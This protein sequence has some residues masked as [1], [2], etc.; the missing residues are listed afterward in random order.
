MT[1]PV[2]PNEVLMTGEN[3]FIRLSS[4]GGESLSDRLSHWRV[5]W[6]PAGAGHALFI[7][8]E[9]TGG[10]FQIY[11]DNIAVARWLQRTIESVLYPAFGDTTVPVRAA[12]FER[13]GDPHS[14]VTELIETD[15]ELIRM[16]WYDC[17]PAFVITSP[18][19]TGGREIGVYSTFFP[20][21]SAQGRSPLLI[22]RPFSLLP[23][24]STLRGAC[25]S[26]KSTA[27]PPWPMPSASSTWQ[28][29]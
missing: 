5:L 20:A 28:T 6:C 21:R 2:D 18:P 15:E 14:T 24:P 11:S 10:E 12:D 7:Q 9:V 16:A 13:Q 3:S 25:S 8:S 29:A 26:F 22:P 27:A 19:G 4:D 17:L 23:R 1:Q